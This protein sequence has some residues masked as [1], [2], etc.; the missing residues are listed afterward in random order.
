M[1]LVS[2]LSEKNNLA[3]IQEREE[4]F[5]REII[6]ISTNQI[7]EK[8]HLDTATF[9]SK[10]IERQD[11][12]EGFAV[13]LKSGSTSEIKEVITDPFI[14]GYVNATVVTIESLR[15]YDHNWKF[16]AEGRTAGAMNINDYNIDYGKNIILKKAAERKGFEQ[17]KIMGGRWASSSGAYYSVLLP[18]GGLRIKGYLEVVVNANLNLPNIEKLI[19]HQIEINN[20]ITGKLIYS[21][22]PEAESSVSLHDLVHQVQYEI[23]S[24]DQR[25]IYSVAV[26]VPN[27]KFM[28]KIRANQRKTLI[29][30]A[31]LNLG[32]M[33]F[34]LILLELLLIRP[35]G[36]LRSDIHRETQALSGE[37]VITSGL[38]E[39][40]ELS[41]DFN[42]LI[43]VAKI[44]SDTLKKI[45][46]IDE[47]T[48]LPNRRALDEFIERSA[49]H[50]IR[51]EEPLSVIMMDID[52]FKKF[53]DT[54]GHQQGDL[55][56]QKVAH[57]IEDALQRAT[58]FVGRYGGEEFTVVLPHT[59]L[60]GAKKVANAILESVRSQKINH[61]ASEVADIVTVSLGVATCSKAEEGCKEILM[62]RAD[63]N[64]YEAK[65]SGRNR[66]FFE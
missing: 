22:R 36:R 21:S 31:L 66:A 44:Q 61:K 50:A 11:F 63:E 13:A 55:C 65:N 45:S 27:T 34:A 41:T 8:L 47:L 28:S 53:N 52:Y 48:Q 42:H 18:I 59:D 62:E 6:S 14:S 9:G 19:G 64:L 30:G 46:M 32:I 12:Q 20:L 38:R 3:S 24:M 1:L 57:A 23:K 58:D 4:D 54:Y 10:F 33:A 17:F 40:Y 5:L 39:F 51:A 2:Y 26:F 56:L 37:P 60:M 43:R 7:Y 35:I 29:T 25:P 15:V 16:L 49:K